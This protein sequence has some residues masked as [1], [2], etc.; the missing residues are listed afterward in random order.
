MR[1]LLDTHAFLWFIAG[2]QRLSN[3]ARELIADID[4]EAHLSVGSLW[5]IA[6]KF[7]IG[8]LTLSEPFE[9]LIS[10][11]LIWNDI[12]VLPIRLADL[13][14]VARLPF[15]HRDPFDRLIIAQ[16]ISNELTIISRDSEFAGY[17]VTTVWKQG[18]ESGN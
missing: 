16:A 2:D 15:H 10:G 6:I 4:N 13:S 17:P 7:S 11:Q 18:A 12:Q 9:D 1:L 14:L 5:E 8:K 3:H